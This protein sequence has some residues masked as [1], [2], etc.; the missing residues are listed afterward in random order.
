[1]RFALLN[2]LVLCFATSAHATTT[3]LKLEGAIDDE[4]MDALVAA[5]KE[6][7]EDKGDAIVLEINSPGGEVDAGFKLVKAIERYHAKVVCIVD[8]EADSMASYIFVGCD[9]RAMTRRSVLMIHQP[10]IGGRGQLNDIQNAVDWI[11]A[12]T[13]AMAEHYAARMRI[14]AVELAAKVAGGRTLWMDWH[15][16]QR[17]GA[18]DIVV[19]RVADLTRVGSW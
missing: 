2:V 5:V 14:S 3:Y 10:S 13:S 1:M 16:A 12:L 4:S 18:V 17:W 9:V 7:P 19:D 6:A 15:A 8:G 11:T